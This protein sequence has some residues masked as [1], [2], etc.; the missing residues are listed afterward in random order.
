MLSCSLK[1]QSLAQEGELSTL[2]QPGAVI[3]GENQ[4]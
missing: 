2:M 4:M 1:W 3:S